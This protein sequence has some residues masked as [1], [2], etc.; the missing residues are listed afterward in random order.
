MVSIKV[1]GQEEMKKIGNP[2]MGKLK[3][4]LKDNRFFGLGYSLK[5]LET[6]FSDEDIEFVYV[7][8]Q[9]YRKKD[10]KWQEYYVR[11]YLQS[12]FHSV[13]YGWFDKER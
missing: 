8:K 12:S 10:G 4:F 1:K 5:D 11:P 7:A 13:N 6:Y 2:G 3:H 9:E